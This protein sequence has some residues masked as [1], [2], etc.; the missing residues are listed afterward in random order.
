MYEQEASSLAP[1]RPRY[2]LALAVAW[3]C[4]FAVVDWS[5]AGS[6][7]AEPAYLPVL[8]VLAWYY[9]RTAGLWLAALATLCVTAVDLAFEPGPGAIALGWAL[10]ANACV[11]GMPAWLAAEL[12]RSARRLAMVM[13]TDAESGLLNRSGFLAR[14]GEELLRTERGG[15]DVSLLAISI[16]GLERLEEEHGDEGAQ[17]LLGGFSEAL[18][19]VARRTDA[20]ARIGRAE[21][22]MLLPGTGAAT[23]RMLAER[24][25]TVLG[26]WLT[27]RAPR[28]GCTVGTTTAPLGRELGAEA[29]LGCAIA[30]REERRPAPPQEAQPAPP[31]AEAPR[32]SGGLVPG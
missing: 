26:D 18:R 21:F 12:G 13:I 27:T 22:A 29:L 15:G 2:P 10:V 8:A 4:A 31:A 7:R 6:W 1:E 3:I 20:V 19:V 5:A 14:V 28:I 32:V 16:D 25:Q 11:Y 24:H 23:S 17:R 30:D 9:G